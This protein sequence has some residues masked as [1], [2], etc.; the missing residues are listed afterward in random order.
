MPL[1]S[2]DLEQPGNYTYALESVTDACGNRVAVHADRH[3][4]LSLTQKARKKIKGDGEST[5]TY[6][7]SVVVH[8]RRNVAFDSRQCRPGHP[9]ALLRNAKGIELTMQSSP[10]LEQGGDWDVKISFEPDNSAAGKGLWARE[11]AKPTEMQL[12][13]PAHS[14]RVPFTVDKPGTY[15]IDDITGPFCA[16]EVGSPWTCEVVDVPPPTADINFSSIEDRCAGPVGVKAMSVLTGNPPFQLEYEVTKEG[17]HPERKVRTI[18]DQTRDELDFR[19]DVDGAVT[20]KFVKLH[21]SNYRGIPLDGPSF[22]QVFHPLSS[23]EF[24]APIRAHD[25]RAVMQSC[26]GKQ[27]EADVRFSG[28]GPWDLTYSVRAADSVETKVVEGIT[29]SLHTLKIDI[30]KSVAA[31]GGL[32]T[33]SLVKIRDARGCEKSLATR[34]LNVEVRRVQPSVGFLPIKADKAGRHLEVL[35]GKPAKLPIRLS[36]QGP[37]HVDY[38]WKANE[39]AEEVD[40]TAS[41]QN[42][43]AELL[44]EHPGLYKIKQIRDNHCPGL[45]LQGQEDF[46]ISVRPQPHVQFANDAGESARNGS[47][48]RA[49]VCR[50]QPD[51]VDIVM[52]GHFPVDVEYEHIAPSWSASSEPEAAAPLASAAHEVSLHGKRRKTAFTSA[53]GSTNL[54]LSTA[55]PGWHTYV[56]NSVGDAVYPPSRLQ[57]FSTESP[58]RLE[59]MVLPLPGASFASTSS[60]HRKPSLCVGDGLNRLESPPTLKL[61]G[62]APFTVSFEVAHA[63]SSS[64]SSAGSYR[65]TRSG[66]KTNE[67]KLDLGGK[68]FAFSS[69]GLWSVRIVQITDANKCETAPMQDS[70][71]SGQDDK[72]MV[73]EVAE[74]ADIAPVSTRED[75]CIGEMVEFSL[76]GSPPWTVSY[77]FNGKSAQAA[78]TTAEFSRVAEKPGV[79]TIKSVA[80][81]QNQ[82]R[83]DVDARVSQDMVKTIHDLP[84]VRISEGNHF[85]EDLREG[86]QAEIIFNFKGVPP[87][88]FTYQRT[89]PVD[90][91][92]RPKVLETNTVSGILEKKYSIWAAVEGTWSVTWLQDR[93]CQVSLDFHSGAATPLGKSRLAIMNEAHSD[94]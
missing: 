24:T 13:L 74:T 31:S 42:V 49:P 14:S 1:S 80:H 19:P 55:L 57:E 38:S 56:I 37:W 23:A 75:Y 30:P 27:A 34:D 20:Y 85:V 22:T 83:R 61:Q 89:E 2:I 87:F 45:V 50:G 53:L 7:Q 67:Y 44:A 6:Q 64:T 68:E 11:A 69:K 54:E 5:A 32:V 72:T 8:T 15:R 52:S 73:I 90:T 26:S 65:F 28:A 3:A 39:S 21:D 41:V 12:S 77:E 81:Q 62:Q 46:R 86:N 33:V 79:L 36:G 82:C 71:R 66:I 43:D 92:A 91:H 9:L 76:Q 70:K 10:D 48:I 59:Q 4:G 18:F 16:G 84:N 40:L 78:V 29:Q 63:G 51:S 17:R 25:D 35:Q 60:K 47:L 93:W 88:S 58:R 94:S